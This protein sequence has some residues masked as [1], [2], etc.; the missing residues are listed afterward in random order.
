[1]A[2]L[3]SCRLALPGKRLSYR[4]QES[5]GGLRRMASLIEYRMRQSIPQQ[6]LAQR[7]RVHPIAR[8]HREE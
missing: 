3:E 7:Y 1:L 5:G 2:L 8:N 6:Y 4:C